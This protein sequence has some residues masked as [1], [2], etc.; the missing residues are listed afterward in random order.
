MEGIE[1]EFVIG[2]VIIGQILSGMVLYCSRG[3]MSL[4]RWGLQT[5]EQ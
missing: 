4:R 3:V 1:L 2:G 5:G